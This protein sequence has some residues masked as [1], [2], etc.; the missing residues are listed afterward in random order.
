MN[1]DAALQKSSPGVQWQWSG[2]AEGSFLG[3]SSLTVKGISKPSVLEAMVCWEALALAQD[4]HVQRITVALD[5]LAVISDMARLYLR[6]YSMI[7]KEI[8]DSAA[9]FAEVS[10]RHES[11]NSN[12]E[13]HRLACSVS[14][15]SIG[16]QVWLLQPPADF[17]IHNNVLFQ[18]S[19]MLPLKKSCRHRIYLLSC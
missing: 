1:V 12:M 10:F 8:K 11:R 6:A 4:L 15:S 7:L 9:S 19:A 2:R 14:S 13:A 5:C 3:A 17:C 16:R 18:E